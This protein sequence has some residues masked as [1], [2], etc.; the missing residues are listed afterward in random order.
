MSGIVGIV[1]AD[2]A[3]VDRLLL[4]DLT[5]SMESRGP[6]G[7]RIWLEDTV[8]LGQAKLATTESARRETQ[9]LTLDGD[10]WIVADAR[11]DGRRELCAELESFGRQGVRDAT[12]AELI[13]HAYGTW[14]DEV[15][16][17]LLGDFSFAIWDGRRR[18]LVCARDPLG[19]KPFYYATWS[20]GM[21]IGNTLCCLR[22]HPAVSSELNERAV[23]DFLLFEWNLDPEAT[24]FADIRRL[25]PAHSLIWTWRG[26]SCR[27][28]WSLPQQQGPEVEPEEGWVEK[29]RELLRIAVEDRLRCERVA[30]LMS[31]GLDSTAVAALAHDVYRVRGQ[32]SGVKCYTCGYE[33]LVADQESSYA[34]LV[35]DRLA[36]PIQLQSA[37]GYRLAERWGELPVSPEPRDHLLDALG[38]DLERQLAERSP[39]A[40]TGLGGDSILLAHT[41]YLLDQVKQGRWISAGAYL[42]GSLWRTGRLPPLGLATRWQ[43]RRLRRTWRSG[44]PQWLDPDLEARFDLEARWRWALL[45]RGPSAPHP[46]HPEASQDLWDTTWAN[47]FEQSDAGAKAFAIELRHPFFDRRLVEYLFTVPPVP[48]CLKKRLLRSAMRGILPERVRLRPKAPLSGPPPHALAQPA[49]RLWEELLGRVPE[50]ERFVRSQWITRDLRRRE[51]AADAVA[52]TDAIYRALSLAYWLGGTNT[53]RRRSRG[54]DRNADGGL[55]THRARD[56]VLEYRTQEPGDAHSRG[57]TR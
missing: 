25:P 6:D 49:S 36:M 24:T 35:A 14:E 16:A 51:S 39:V 34:R 29:F 52:Y 31:G 42:A 32:R 27:R 22:R 38:Y 7:R 50:I 53:G 4:A 2:G 48:W 57:N 13:L 33:S 47:S 55:A 28:Y 9:P 41:G 30:V 15:A 44:Y 18:R 11:I 10:V 20:G 19:V 37:D 17:H 21:V 40:L 45:E 12:D 54:R 23:A 43:K 5:D 46:R 56:V 8:G 3:P 1:H 26:V